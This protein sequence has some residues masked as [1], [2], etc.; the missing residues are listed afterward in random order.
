MFGLEY[1]IGICNVGFFCV[2]GFNFFSFFFIDVIGGLCLAGIYC[3]VGISVVINCIV[4][5]YI[6]VD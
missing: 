5:I 4:G 6:D 1:F 3:L 2:G